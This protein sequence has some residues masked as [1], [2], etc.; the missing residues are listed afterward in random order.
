LLIAWGVLWN[1]EGFIAWSYVNT[2]K[3][4]QSDYSVKNDQG[5]FC[6][7]QGW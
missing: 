6:L 3:E 4:M 7:I 1:R 2:S 5:A